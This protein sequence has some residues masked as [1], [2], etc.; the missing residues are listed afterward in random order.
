MWGTVCVARVCYTVYLNDST[1]W[2]EL[3]W[4]KRT[5]RS[6]DL[7]IHSTKLLGKTKVVPCTCM[8]SFLDSYQE[9]VQYPSLYARARQSQSVLD[10]VDSYIKI[11]TRLGASITGTAIGLISFRRWDAKIRWKSN[12]KFVALSPR[13]R[14]RDVIYQHVAVGEQFFIFNSHSYNLQSAVNCRA[15]IFSPN[16]KISMWCTTTYNRMDQRCKHDCENVAKKETGHIFIR[17]VDHTYTINRWRQ[18]HSSHI[19]ITWICWRNVMMR[20]SQFTRNVAVSL[21][22]INTSN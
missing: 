19:V 14:K 16:S 13:I 17:C 6:V 21:W 7:K 2:S 11:L 9:N 1:F 20:I 3:K 15:I 12:F 5:T 10:F 18:R 8:K 4:V 22:T